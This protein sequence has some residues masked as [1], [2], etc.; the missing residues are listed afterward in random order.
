LHSG[1]APW[2]P[3]AQ[4]PPPPRPPPP[5]RPSPPRIRRRAPPGADPAEARPPRAQP[6]P[7]RADPK[8]ADPTGR[9]RATVAVMLSDE[10]LM[11][12][13]PDI[14]VDHDNAAHYRGLL[15]RRLVLNR[16]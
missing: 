12:A 6:H 10:E 9:C 1:A 2:T 13:L 7:E 8:W 5:G 15:E 16:C 4:R 3:A 11:D 14:R